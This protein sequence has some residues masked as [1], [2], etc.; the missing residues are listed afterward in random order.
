MSINFVYN[1]PVIDVL[2]HPYPVEIILDLFQGS[3][4]AHMA[5]CAGIVMAMS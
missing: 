2:L 3:V 4:S 1:Y 5:S